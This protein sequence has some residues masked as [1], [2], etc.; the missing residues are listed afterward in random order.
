VSPPQLS[1]PYPFFLPSQHY[2]ARVRHEEL[3][4]KT[5]TAPGTADALHP[6]QASQALQ[7]LNWMQQDPSKKGN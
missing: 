4:E 6:S 5:Y 3:E 7:K 1:S 2:P